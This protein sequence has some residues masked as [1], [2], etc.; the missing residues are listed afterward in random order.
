MC[1]NNLK[2]NSVRRQHAVDVKSSAV[3]CRHFNPKSSLRSFTAA[4]G[5]EVCEWDEH[6]SAVSLTISHQCP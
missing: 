4:R 5:V 1:V 3:F 6:L 2:Y